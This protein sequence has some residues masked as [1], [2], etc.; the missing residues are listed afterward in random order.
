MAILPNLSFSKLKEG[1]SKTRGALFSKIGNVFSNKTIFIEDFSAQI[2]EILLES[3]F[4]V[5]LT[6]KLL[7]AARKT[8]K[9]KNLND[10]D[11]FITIIKNELLSE[12]KLSSYPK[13]LKKNIAVPYVIILLGINGSGK[14]TTLGKLAHYYKTQNMKVIVG[15]ADTFRAAANDQ[16]KNWAV[17]ANVEIVEGTMKDPSAV[18]FETVKLAVEQKFDIVLIDTAGRLH[19][20]KNLM[21]ELNKIQ[22]VV[23]GLL[24]SAPHEVFLV[25]DGNSGQ[26][27]K[28]QALE[29]GNYLNLTGLIVTKLD[30]TAKGGAVIQIASNFKLPIK[31]IG[32]G[33]K[34]ED[35]EIFDPNNYIDALFSK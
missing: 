24:T 19:T 31:Y 22:K 2:E 17:Q 14:T 20:N 6:E 33:E 7:F 34:I 9:D 15:A 25:I 32:I 1:L 35:L 21:N 30:G 23:S 18:A 27:A 8:F 29:F 26:N 5:E 4:G 13:L 16:L 12:L 3:D 11:D 10:F 28:I